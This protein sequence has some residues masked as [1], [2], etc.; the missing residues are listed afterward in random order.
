M[1]RL[2]LATAEA[3]VLRLTLNDPASRNS[4]SEAMMAELQT[5]LDEAAAALSL[6]LTDEDVAELEAPYLPHPVAGFR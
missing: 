3:G 2:L 1:T 5:A 4:L 6:K